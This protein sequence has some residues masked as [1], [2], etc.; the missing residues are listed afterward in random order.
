MRSTNFEKP[1]SYIRTISKI[2]CGER[3][4]GDSSARSRNEQ[5]MKT[6]SEASWTFVPGLVDALCSSSPVSSPELAAGGWL[7]A[8]VSGAVAP[9]STSLSMVDSASVS[10]LSLSESGGLWMGPGCSKSSGR[11][12]RNGDAGGLAASPPCFTPSSLLSLPAVSL[13]RMVFLARVASRQQPPIQ[14]GVWRTW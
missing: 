7:I 6:R 12:L 13:S 11:M 2:S 8:W 10:V 4:R 14:K 9:E 1:L 3:D 5:N